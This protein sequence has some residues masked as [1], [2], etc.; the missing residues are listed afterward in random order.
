ML[1]LD[2]VFFANSDPDVNPQPAPGSALLLPW[3]SGS[4]DRRLSRR[5]MAEENS[6][7]A[8]VP[9]PAAG[10]EEGRCRELLTPSKII[11]IA[12]AGDVLVTGLE[13]R[14][15]DTAAFQRLRR[16]RQLGTA[17]Y[18]YPSSLHTRFDHSL[19]TLAMAARIIERVRA[20]HDST[21]EERTISMQQ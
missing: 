21:A 17:S 7:V 4:L 3:G 13:L 9:L 20:N 12:V 10:P 15:I 16:V 2:A 6:S 11:R 14:L 19:G 5:F 1:V 18:V 8:R